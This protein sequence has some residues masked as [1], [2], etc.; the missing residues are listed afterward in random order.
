MNTD[1]QQTAPPLQIFQGT[2]AVW[3]KA[4]KDGEIY[5]SINLANFV[6]MHL[7]EI[8]FNQYTKHMEITYRY[9]A[10]DYDT[11]MAYL[12]RYALDTLCRFLTRNSVPYEIIPVESYTPKMVK[13][14]L[15]K[16][17]TPRENQVDIINFLSDEKLTY[18]PLSA[19]CSIG[20]TVMSIM[21]MSHHGM[22][23][24]IVLPLLIPQWYK[25]IFQFTR[26]KK[27]DV[28][29]IKGFDRL[30]NLWKMHEQGYK[31]K[32]IIF[33]SR[34]LMLYA[35]TKTEGYA[36]LPSYAEFQKQFGIGVKIIDEVHLGFNA[37]VL[38]DL[39]SNIRHNIYLSATYGR[40]SQSGQAIFSLVF[41]TSVVYH[42]AL[43]KKFTVVHPVSYSLGMGGDES[44]FVKQK[45]Y[46]QA[47]YENYILKILEFKREFMNVVI[48]EVLTRFYYSRHQPQYRVLI[49]CQ[50]QKFAEA[51]AKA[52]MKYVNNNQF[53]DENGAV[54]PRS[55][56]VFFSG[57]T[58]QD[59]LQKDIL[60][61]TV[62]SCGTG[63]DLKRLIC[64][65]NTLSFS[66]SVL[67][68]QMMG[69]LRE[70]PGE[71]T[72]FVDLWCRDV[73]SH[74]RHINARKEE[75]IKIAKRLV[76]SRI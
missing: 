76:E 72:H 7:Q 22:V 19:Q 18:H 59:E 49:L 32:I 46:N 39:Q 1:I 61:S 26:L 29:V 48:P 17:V 57:T 10:Y 14:P 36:D 63:M 75:Y 69:R 62:K 74:H 15:K 73:P 42:N 23:S 65:I 43:R 70:I 4:K 45:G 28:Y 21:A 9:S 67:T 30:Q 25:S 68:V 52:V 35:Y 34:T 12:P 3:F 37:N 66:S 11:S 54:F 71:E 60:I 27:E 20:K 31:P 50:T 38:I 64:C 47:L 24:M 56:G 53:T 41:P 13:I 55:I 6:H 5:P 8:D 44:P 33:A 16:N 40:S 51:I 2:T 58:S